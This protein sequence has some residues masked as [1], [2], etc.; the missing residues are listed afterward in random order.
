MRGVRVRAQF[1]RAQMLDPCVIVSSG[2]LGGIKEDALANRCVRGITYPL[3]RLRPLQ[4]ARERAFL[5]A[6]RQ[7]TY[8]RHCRQ[9]LRKHREASS[10]PIDLHIVH[11]LKDKLVDHL[12]RPNCPTHKLQTCRRRVGVNKVVRI[13]RRQRSTADP[14][15]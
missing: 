7:V 11:K 8:T 9:I 5:S 13:E 4:R 3:A 15:G 2:R 12:V 1:A 14:A 6:A 10:H